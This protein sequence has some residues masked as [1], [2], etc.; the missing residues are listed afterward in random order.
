MFLFLLGLVY[1]L[2]SQEVDCWEERLQNV[3]LP[4]KWDVKH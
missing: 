4:I 1:Y 3:L 2:P